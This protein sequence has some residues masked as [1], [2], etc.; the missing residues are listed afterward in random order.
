MAE[1]NEKAFDVDH[2]D[3]LHTIDT[4]VHIA[5]ETAKSNVSPWTWPMFRLYLV[6]GVAYLCGFVFS[7][8]AQP[9]FRPIL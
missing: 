4:A 7:S 9:T 8:L 2:H 3:K 5:H 1:T 6:L